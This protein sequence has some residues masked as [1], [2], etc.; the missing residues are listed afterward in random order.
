MS[1]DRLPKEE[2]MWETLQKETAKTY[3]QRALAKTRPFRAVILKQEGKTTTSK[4]YRF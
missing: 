3:I 4:G 2:N 1:L